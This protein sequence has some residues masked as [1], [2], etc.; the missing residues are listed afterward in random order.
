MS[1]RRIVEVAAKVAVPVLAV[2]GLG[3][4]LTDA[5]GLPRPVPAAERAAPGA[6]PV[7]DVELVCPGPETIGV[8]GALRAESAPAPARLTGASPP[9]RVRGAGV[10]PGRLRIETAVGG[11]LGGGADLGSGGSLA[12]ASFSLARSVSVRATGSAAPGAFAEQTTTVVKGDLR[13]LTTTSCQPPAD[14]VWL[15]G[16]G[17]E[18]GRRG[19]LV[20]TNPR[21]SAAKVSVDVLSAT[22]PVRRTPGSTLPVPARSRVVVLLDALAPGV[23][24]PVVRV[25]S[26][27]GP[28]AAT[29]HDARLDGIVPRGT[30]DVS[31]GTAPARQV[32]VPGVA[33]PGR[34]GSAALLRVGVPGPDDAVAQVRLIGEQGPVELP[35][36]GVLRVRA[37]STKDVDLSDLPAG[38]Y[39]VLITA[40]VPV[41]AGAMTERRPKPGGPSDFAWV[42][43]AAPLGKV[44]GVAATAPPTVAAVL[45][46]APGPAS[47]SLG[48]VSVTAQGEVKTSDL[49]ISAGSSR[50]IMLTAG[51]TTWLVPK[52]GS[53]PVV[54]ARFL[55]LDDPAGPLIAS[56]P[57]R[58]A[59]LTEVPPDV[60]P[61]P[62]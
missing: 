52:R 48:V 59:V 38:P 35:G 45:L 12:T 11:L 13:G 2:G 41:V 51:R 4:V 37:S 39:A 6:V 31:A 32:R 10:G 30:D 9:S 5:P 18:E 15:V 56:A 55:R 29:L 23:T 62:D 43:S 58:S 25:R 24:S 50:T 8:R 34:G 57:L 26:S 19:R 14:D 33:L 21:G 61:A 40:D 47:G 3:A 1:L 44:T 17:G 20:I 36:G 54:G 7:T 49:Q 46:S 42:G 16:G 28:V 53:G 22:G 60:A 27:D